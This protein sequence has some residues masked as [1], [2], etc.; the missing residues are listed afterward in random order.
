[1]NPSAVTD[2][3]RALQIPVAETFKLL[4]G[5]WDCLVA[6]GCL[7]AVKF[8][9]K[10]PARPCSRRDTVPEMK[11]TKKKYVQLL[12]TLSFL[13]PF[14]CTHLGLNHPVPLKSHLFHNVAHVNLKTDK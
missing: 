13:P 1:M 11:G 9:V 12:F 8:P 14:V 7:E 2:V 10:H 6:T 4:C 3:A 5:L